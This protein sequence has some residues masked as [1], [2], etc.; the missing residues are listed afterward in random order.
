MYEFRTSPPSALGGRLQFR[1]RTLLLAV[2][3]C[4]L[5]FATM[6]SVGPTG[7]VAL[8]FGLALVLLHV[9]G[10]GL[11]TSLRDQATAEKAPEAIMRSNGLGC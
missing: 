5:L 11:G 1:L 6:R 3:G 8:L 10:N 2:S 4:C 9:L 7:S